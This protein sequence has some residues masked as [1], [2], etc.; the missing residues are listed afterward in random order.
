MARNRTPLNSASVGPILGP[1]YM[2]NVRDR[3]KDLWDVSSIQLGTIAGT[4]NAITATCDPPLTGG[5]TAGMKFS[6]IAANT[7]SG[8][9]TIAI[10][11][12]SAINLRDDSGASLLAG[13]I[14]AGRLYTLEADG[15]NIRVNN[16]SGV[17]KIN[18]YQV[19]TASGTWNK[20]AGCPANALVTVQVWSGGGGGGIGTSQVVGGGGGGGCVIYTCKAG[21]LLASVAVTIGAGGAAGSAGGTSSFGTLVTSFGGG[22]GGNQNSSGATGGGGGG[23]NQ[24]GGNGTT[25]GSGT[26]PPTAA[27]DFTAGVSAGTNSS[28]LA[29]GVGLYNY[30]YY[31]GGAGGTMAGS[32]LAG[33][34]GG[35]SVWGAGGG[36]S[37]LG[38][39]G[40][41]SQFGGAGGAAGAAGTAPGGG[42]GS[43]AAGARGEIRVYVNG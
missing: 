24:A 37:R 21:D 9:V 31:G 33:D 5:I 16:T 3:I 6:F 4:G 7:N 19:F 39:G 43:N 34:P 42:G 15:T 2:D 32:P 14:V 26:N 8:G 25:I 20:P 1:T 22:R 12:G 11:G 40:G 36:S 17:I 28:T 23:A 10:D 38:S 18:D 27:G 13:S 29:P 41:T 30:G 35:K